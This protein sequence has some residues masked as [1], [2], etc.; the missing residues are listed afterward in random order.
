MLPS[1]P[2]D[3]VVSPSNA[4]AIADCFACVRALADAAASLPLL[5]YKRQ[6]G[7][8]R[9]RVDNTTADLLR[10]PAPA[11][12]Q[13]NFVG[14]IVAHL[15]LHGNAFCGK[16]KGADGTIT[17]LGLLPPNAMTIELK[18]GV[19][20]YTF[21]HPT[22]GKRDVL[23]TGDVI[24]VKSLS[25]DGLV[26]LS[27][28]RQCRMALGLS[29]QLVEHA[30]RFF[31]A[32]ARPSGVLR[33]PPGPAAQDQVENL[34]KAWEARH[35]GLKQSHRVA[36]VSGDLSFQA[37]GM[38]LEDAQFLQ[39]RQLSA[40]EVAR[41]FRVPPSVIGA[42]TGDSLTY[43]TVEQQSLHFAMYSLRPH[44]V[45]IEQALSNDRDL[46]GPNEYAEFLI[47][48]LLRADTATR[49][50]TYATA[51]DH[52]W[53]TVDE[54]RQ[55]ENLPPLPTGARPIPKPSVNGKTPVVVNA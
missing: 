14:Q 44:L 35:A 49:S 20:L 13:A 11:V 28:V 25:T 55:R 34:R 21:T 18:G 16:Y 39:Q 17:Q 52:G 41:I 22:T 24:H 51:L 26:G 3:T 43:A 12:T 7:G 31:E 33:V 47:D 6:S 42:P 10:Q 30:S 2:G 50:S 1:V 15:N 19:P 37:V 23:T 40:Q 32:D 48:A 45:Q 9:D 27:P 46:F 53:M 38:P 5:V 4:M 54:V 29:S 36:I 8:G